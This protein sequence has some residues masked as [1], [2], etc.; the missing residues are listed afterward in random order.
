MALKITYEIKG[1]GRK[2]LV[3]AISQV[4]NFASVYKGVPNFE[5]KIGDLVVDRLHCL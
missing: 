4:L 5:Y 3:Q 2:E 1:K